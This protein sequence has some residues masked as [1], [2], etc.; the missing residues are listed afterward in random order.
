[1]DNLTRQADKDEGIPVVS[2]RDVT[3][4]Y[5]L[6]K[7]DIHALRG[8]SL[9][10]KRGEFLSIVGP[11]GCGKSTLLNMIGCID[12][13][14]LGQVFLMGRDTSTFN[15]DQ[16]ADARLAEIGFIFQS[17]NLVGVLDVRENIELPLRLAKKPA[18]ERKV[19]VDRLVA[20]VGLE[21]YARHKPDELS[22]GQRQRVAIARALVNSPS[23]VIADEPTANLDTKT[24]EMVMEIMA[25]LNVKEGVTFI[26]STHNELI[27]HYARR[28]LTLQDGL[29]V[30]ETRKECA[31]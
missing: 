5:R 6:G 13:P 7:T 17:F 25:E 16:E 2:V 26:F 1:M 12:Q 30:G 28:V 24:S 29:I 27:E 3:K 19:I 21:P 4:D 31:A 20:A 11:S 18:A 22:G 23:L 9:D 14:S 10:I 8:V 15:D